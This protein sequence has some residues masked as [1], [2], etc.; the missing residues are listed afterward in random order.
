M[1]KALVL[2]AFSKSALESIQSLGRHGVEVHAAS[3]RDCLAFR[4]RRLHRSW[5][6]PSTTDPAAFLD[7]LRRLDEEQGYTLI[8]PSTEFSLLPISQI[9][10]DDPLRSKAQLPNQLS[11]ET[12][13]DKWKTI[14][15]GQAV[16]MLTPETR[17]ISSLAGV[18]VPESFP[19]VLK[20]VRSVVSVEQKAHRMDSVLVHDAIEWRRMLATMLQYTSV[21]EQSRLSGRGVGIEMLYQ[22]GKR[23]W[24]FAHRRLH[25][26]S[27]GSGLGSASWYRCSISPPAR[28]LKQVTDLMDRLRWHGVAMVEF[29]QTTDGAY[30]LM[31]INPRLW[32]SVGLAIRSGVDFPWGL[33]LNATGTSLGGQPAYRVPYYARAIEEDSL[34][35]LSQLRSNLT[36]GLRETAKLFRPLFGR[37]S[38]D[39]FDWGDLRPISGNLSQLTKRVAKAVVKHLRTKYQGNLAA[40]LHDTNLS[41]IEKTRKPIRNVLILC[42]G[43]ICRSPFAE[44]TLKR[45]LPTLSVASAGFYPQP[46]R[47]SPIPF[48][49]AALSLGCDLSDHRSRVVSREMVKSADVVLLM[50]VSNLDFFRRQ[51]STELGK[52][53][54]LGHFLS[55]PSDIRDPYDSN[56]SQT[57][58]VLEQIVE[59]V[60]R[61]RGMC[62]RTQDS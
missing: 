41:R 59:A 6:Q 14:Q 39:Y 1:L 24:Y 8:I 28:L 11:L 19:V 26:G 36:A 32:G 4:S 45:R 15:A 33:F 48:R 57:I 12:A 3:P 2:D 53:L 27:V 54:M 20:S 58:N 17:L 34:W 46:G 40:R 37:E 49:S 23:C 30:W 60:E 50:D 35:I 52:I 42:Y 21:L 38:W 55:S 44:A 9:S 56:L 31:E 13:L 43:N 51:F 47:S 22:H 5:E 25:E 7:W 61:F 29:L 18:E 16:G 10:D 62:E